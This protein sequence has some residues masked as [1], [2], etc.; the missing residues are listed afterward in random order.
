MVEFDLLFA[1]FLR[2]MPGCDCS[3][4]QCLYLTYFMLPHTGRCAFTR[5]LKSPTDQVVWH[6]ETG[7]YYMLVSARDIQVFA[8]VQI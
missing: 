3:F 8:A 4:C 2:H 7:D 1:H 6:D 5:R